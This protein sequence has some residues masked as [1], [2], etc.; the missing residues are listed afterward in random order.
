MFWVATTRLPTALRV[1]LARNSVRA[2]FP[3]PN[4]AKLAGYRIRYGDPQDFRQSWQEVFVKGAYLFES[5][6][7]APRIIDAGAN[8]GLATLYFKLLYPRARVLAI[9]AAPATF[10][11]LA[12]N[13]AANVPDVAVEH[14]A[15]GGSDGETDFFSLPGSPL[16]SLDGRSGGGERAR[17]PMRRLS[18]FLDEEVDLLKIDIEGA[19]REVL[20]E[21]AAAGKLRRARQN[22]PRVPPPPVARRGPAVRDA[23][24][25]GGARLRLP[26]VGVALPGPRAGAGAGRGRRDLGVPQ[27][28]P[29]PGAPGATGADAARSLDIA[30]RAFWWRPA[31]A[32]QYR[33]M[34]E[35][36]ARAGLRLEPPLADLGCGT[37]LFAAMLVARGV[38]GGT[39]LGLD[40][41]LEDLRRTVHRPTL[42]LLRGDMQ[43]LP[44]AD[45][46]LGSAV[47]HCVLSSF[48][49]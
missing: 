16:G 44:F 32:L 12:E 29:A 26:G 17:V 2:A 25:P 35:A 7:P 30:A 8:I 46:S 11:L 41:Q 13:V 14:C 45:G 3:L 33:L 9:E 39:D 5:D 24:A 42:G 47:S 38:V 27:V 19:E 18:G 48:V 36:Y 49:G 21:L 43:A 40:W 6:K 31:L 37:G 28:A 20:P 34:L 1:A 22:P 23:A 4:P 15:L 10:G